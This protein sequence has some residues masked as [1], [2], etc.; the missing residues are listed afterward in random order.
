MIFDNYSSTGLFAL[1][2]ADDDD[3]N[4]DI[5]DDDDTATEPDTQDN[6]DDKDTQEPDDQDDDNYDVNDDEPDD[7]ENQ[8]DN[9]DDNPDDDNQEGEPDDQDDDNYDINDDEPE[10]GQDNNDQ[11]DNPEGGDSDDPREKLKALEK[12]IFDQLSP[13]QQKSKT[14]ELKSLFITAHSKCQEI[15]DMVAHSD[16]D[17]NQAKVYDYIVNR[18]TELKDY[19]TDYMH[20]IFDSKTYLENMTEFQKYLAVFDTIK[21]IFDE[22]GKDNKNK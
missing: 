14:K 5:K 11:D 3:D 12:S 17:P 13:E 18:L 20:D 9:K 15:I 4:Y 22:I 1:N 2:E 6:T 7:E 16:R 21:N 10:E 19:I 8:D